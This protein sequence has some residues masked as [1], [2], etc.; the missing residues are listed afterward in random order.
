MPT[1]RHFTKRIAESLL[2]SQV[3]S[4][5]GSKGLKRPTLLDPDKW[6][7][8]KGWLRILTFE[9]KGKKLSVQ[10]F[11]LLR[12]QWVMEMWIPEDDHDFVVSV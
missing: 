7:E 5:A 8:G 1:R 11:S 4:L 12:Q 2:A 10:I 9:P 6:I 3:E